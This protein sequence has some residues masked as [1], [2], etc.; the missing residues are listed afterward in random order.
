MI[1]HIC[2]SE[3]D[4]GETICSLSFAKRVRGIETNREI[5][6]VIP[7]PNFF[8]GCFVWSLSPIW[9]VL[10]C[11]RI[12]AGTEEPEWEE[13]R[14]TR[15]TDKGYG[16]WVAETEEPNRKSWT[17]ADSGTESAEGVSEKPPDHSSWRSSRN[18]ANC[19]K[20]IQQSTQCIRSSLH[21]FDSSKPAETNCERTTS[22]WENADTE[23]RYQKPSG[24]TQLA[25]SQLFWTFNETKPCQVEE[26]AYDV[27]D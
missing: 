12:R 15:S 19:W 17:T 14:W 3:D 18:S 13:H 10:D 22:E 6:E 4:V 2:P 23:D 9:T 24:L 11:F 1:V 16:S 5:S 21:D 7:P 20:S 25:V 27:W 8:S 26:Q